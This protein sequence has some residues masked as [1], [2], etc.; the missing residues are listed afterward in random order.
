MQKS[1]LG[2]LTPREMQVL[3]L[4]SRGQKNG[5]IARSLVISPGTAKL[6]VH[7]VITKLGVSDRTQAA[8]VAISSHIFE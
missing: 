4:L 7:R 6:H 1:L 3:Y 2:L 8:I 5:Q